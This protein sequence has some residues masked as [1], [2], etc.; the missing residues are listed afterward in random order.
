MKKTYHRGTSALCGAALLLAGAAPALAEEVT[1]RSADGTVDLTGEF[2]EF[3]ENAYVIRTALGELRLSAERVRCE[4][5]ACPSFD[6][7]RAGIVFA[8]SDAVGLGMMPL[9][10]EGYAGFLDAEATISATGTPNEIL[11]SLVGDGG[12]G[13]DM[14]EMVVGS[15]SSSDAFRTLLGASADIG[16]AARRIRPEE[17]RALRDAGAGNMVDPANEHIV[18]VDSLVVI[19][20]PDNPVGTLTVA[21]LSDVYRGEIRNWSEVGGPDLPIRVIDRPSSSGTRDVFAE[22]IF[23]TEADP[24]VAP[25]EVRIANDNNEVARLVNEDPA[26]IGFVGYAFQRGAKPVTLVNS[27]GLTMTPDAF[28]ARTE[29][30]AL[31]RRLYLYNRGDEM[32]EEAGAFLDYALSPEAD[33][34]IRKA[35]F[36]D[37]GVE[38]RRQ[39]MDGDRAR[40]LLDPEAD[41]YEGALMREMLG[42]MVDYERLSTTF[43][44]RTGSSRLDE[45]ALVDMQRL[46]TFLQEAPE[47]SDVLV[48]GFT[49]SVGS[50]D[51]NRDLSVERADQVLL[52]LQERIGELPGVTMRSAGFGEI[53][54]S[55]CNDTDR[56][57]GINRRVEVWMQRPA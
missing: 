3:S 53:A 18:A 20:H 28:S 16:M 10:L 57:R 41:P 2:V 50:F 4:G 45:R 49:D 40:Q 1:L 42:V 33:S 43:R 15:T 25:L 29:E 39:N 11:V 24:N 55:G 21:Q 22:T 27:C 31:Q 35:G 38:A 23:T 52:E 14:G 5:A 13:D 47:G 46:A 37:L 8:G 30:Y 54:P 17:A 34:V 32:P 6:T 12:F 19:V 36:I 26:A 48:V 56:G 51:A 7:G 9:L 44:F